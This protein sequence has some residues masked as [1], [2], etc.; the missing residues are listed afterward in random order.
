MTTPITR[1]N[2]VLIDIPMPV[3]TDRLTIRPPQPGDGIRVT[4]AKRETWA[5]LT[6]WMDWATGEP[7]PSADEAVM[8][9]AQARFILRTDLMM[10]AFDRTTGKPVVFTGLHRNNWHA[11]IFEIGYWVPTSARGQGY[12]TEAANALTRFAFQALAARKVIITHAAGNEASAAV[13]HR[14]GYTLESVERF[15]TTLPDS[16][17]VDQYRYARFDANGLPDL[18]IRW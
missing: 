4:E 13:I 18:A 15:G 8:R 1:I 7:D 17:V 16:T 12:A 14:L 3:E 6:R 9:E 11:R 5:D 10:L 2:P